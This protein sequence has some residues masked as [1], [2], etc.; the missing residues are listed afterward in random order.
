VLRWPLG[1][2][3]YYLLLRG[4]T[5]GLGLWFAMGSWDKFKKWAL[6]WL[7]TLAL[8]IIHMSL[9]VIGVYLLQYLGEV[10]SNVTE[11]I[12]EVYNIIEAELEVIIRESGDKA[13][14]DHALLGG[15]VRYV[16]SNLGYF[17]TCVVLTSHLTWAVLSWVFWH[18]HAWAHHWGF[19]WA[20]ISALALIV[21]IW[22]IVVRITTPRFRLEALSRLGWE[23]LLAYLVCIWVIYWLGFWFL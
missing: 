13:D 10:M 7:E 12:P 5:P 4:L 18:L 6:A 14:P 21:F 16:R 23:V 19:G 9:W 17:C 3:L 15:L 11:G 2:W 8:P 1:L 20:A 22:I